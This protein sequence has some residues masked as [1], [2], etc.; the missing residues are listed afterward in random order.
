MTKPAPLPTPKTGST[1]ATDPLSADVV[2]AALH[3]SESITSLRVVGTEHELA[4]PAKNVF[5]IGTGAVDVRVPVLGAQRPVSREH[6][7]LTRQGSDDGTWL[8]VVDLGSLNGTFFEGGR[9]RDFAVKAGQR[10]SVAS[11]ELL[12]MDKSLA[13]LRR[14]LEGFFGATEHQLLDDHLTL[15]VEHDAIL[16][17]G[18]RGSERGHLAHAIHE[19]SRRR[20]HPFREVRK[21]SGDPEAL[22]ADFRA[23]AHGTMFVSLDNLGGKA[24]VGPLIKL[25]FDPTYAVRPII[26]AR[27][28]AQVCAALN[29][30][31]TRF[32]PL[33]LPP[34]RERPGDIP[35]LLDAM[36]AEWGSPHRVVE[37]KP[38]RL[39]AMCDFEWPRNRAELRETAQRVGALLAHRGNLSAAAKAI[40]QDYESFRRA[41]ARVGAI[42]VQ[43]RDE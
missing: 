30:T 24:G 10:F 9:E 23:A 34:V 22:V 16:L 15:L 28:L 3:S 31:A 35:A 17:L 2:G 1:G 38:D 29:V 19:C 5:R 33:T 40:H 13:Q 6:A 36:L 37:L 42:T 14:V 11:T 25:L 12:V 8:Q 32:R 21:P 43:H 39:A 26:A 7:E 27:D 20:R 4:L 18:D 41:L